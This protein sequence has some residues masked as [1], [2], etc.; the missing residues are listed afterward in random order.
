MKKKNSDLFSRLTNTKKDY[1][2]DEK[3]SKNEFRVDSLEIISPTEIV[4]EGVHLNGEK[5]LQGQIKFLERI[6][7]KEL[8]NNINLFRKIDLES[9]TDDKLKSI[10]GNIICFNI[11]S[12]LVITEGTSIYRARNHTFK[13]E[14]A[15]DYFKS[16][17]EVWYP[18]PEFL[19]KLGRLNRVSQPIM[20]ASF[21]AITPTS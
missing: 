2:G 12:S 15:T 3:G 1:K 17:S 8:L 4:A 16:A 19:T 13:F 10:L 6:N 7:Q 20:Y 18:A 11:F 21:D 5:I 9:V 14:K